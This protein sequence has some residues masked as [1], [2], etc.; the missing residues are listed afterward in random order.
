M[1]DGFLSALLYF[2]FAGTQINKRMFPV[3]VGTFPIIGEI[4]RYK[5]VRAIEY[6][7][8]FHIVGL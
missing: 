4:T 2:Q 7:Q 1:Q 5:H 3:L 6:I 8:S